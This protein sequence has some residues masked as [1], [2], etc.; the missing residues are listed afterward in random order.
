M[1][2]SLQKVSLSPGVKRFLATESLYGLSIGMFTLI[3]NLHLIEM[4][5]SEKQIGFITSMGILAEGDLCYYCHLSSQ[6]NRAEK[7]SG[8]WYWECGT[9]LYDICII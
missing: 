7:A 2:Q 9:W 3:L 6:K 8:F 4:G 1:K 5:I